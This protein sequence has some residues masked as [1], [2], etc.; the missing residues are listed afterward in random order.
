[1]LIA[2]YDFAVH[3]VKAPFFI[4]RLGKGFYHAH[5]GHVFLHLAHHGVHSLL[6]AHIQRDAF[7]RN[8]KHHY[9]KKRQCCNEHKRQHGLKGKCNADASKQQ[10]RCTNAK[11][12]HAVHHLVNVVSIACKAGNKGW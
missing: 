7:T 8:G 3:F 10:D 9:A 2:P 12:L 1:M 6:H 11:A 4:I 5:T